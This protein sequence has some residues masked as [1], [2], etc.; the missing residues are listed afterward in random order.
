[1]SLMHHKLMSAQDRI[2]VFHYLSITYLSNNRISRTSAT[3]LGFE[4]YMKLHPFGRTPLDLPQAD[5]QLD[6]S[7]PIN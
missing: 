7:R 4:F 6:E 3:D 5:T 1:M 2:L